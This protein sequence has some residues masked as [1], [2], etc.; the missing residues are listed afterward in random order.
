M[1][2]NKLRISQVQYFSSLVYCILVCKSTIFN[3]FLLIA[4]ARRKHCEIN[5]KK[6]MKMYLHMYG[7]PNC[8]YIF[9]F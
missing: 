4:I 9:V 7:K 2:K 3:Y 1:D 6:F 5:N 8:N